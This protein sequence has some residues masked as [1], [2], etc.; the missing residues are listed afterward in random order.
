MWDIHGEAYADCRV[1]RPAAK[2]HTFPSPE[3]SPSNTAAT[4]LARSK[5]AHRL[6]TLRRGMM[7]SYT[8]RGKKM[9]RAQN[10]TRE[11][12]QT[13]EACKN[14]SYSWPHA[15][16]MTYSVDDGCDVGVAL[17]NEVAVH[18]GG[19]AKPNAGDHIAFLLAWRWHFPFPYSQ[20][21]HD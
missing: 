16:S 14:G 10:K 7:S 6:W 4:R 18:R 17:G 20:D 1:G 8:S 11:G 19:A 12:R 15:M 2:M 9:K 3:L 13:E 21:T 5:K